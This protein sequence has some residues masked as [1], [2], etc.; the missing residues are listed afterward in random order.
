MIPK[1]WNTKR[2]HEN[3]QL[4][5]TISGDLWP[6]GMTTASEAGEPEFDPQVF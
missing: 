3:L 2:E 5:L 1:S 6:S 4:Q